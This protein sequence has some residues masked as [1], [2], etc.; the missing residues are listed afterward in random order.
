[1]HPVRRKK[2]SKY[3]II[4]ALITV[5]TALVMYALRQNISLFHTPTDVVNKVVAEGVNIRVGGRVVPGSIKHGDGL[6]VCFQL[7][8]TRHTIEVVYQGV[9]PDLFGENQGVVVGGT[10]LDQQVQ[11]TQV[12]AKHDENYMPPEAKYALEKGQA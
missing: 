4:L 8:D 9:L 12:L 5:I 10:V 1:M 2:L 11:A 3:L 7:T 6:S